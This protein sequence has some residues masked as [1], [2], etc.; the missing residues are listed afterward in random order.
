MRLYKIIYLLFSTLLCFNI[1][2]QEYEN[3]TVVAEEHYLLQYSENGEG[4]GPTAE[5]LKALFKE[6]KISVAINFMPWPRAYDMAYNNKNTIVLSLIRT[7]EREKYFHWIGIVSELSRV[8]ISLN[9]KPDNLITDISQAKDKLIAVTRDS[10]SFHELIKLGFNENKNL[11]IVSNNDSA[12][13][14]LLNGKVDLVYHDPN[15]V[16]EFI[17]KSKNKN[18]QINFTP[19]I[20]ADRRA[21]YIAININSDKA[22]VSNLKAAMAKYQQT[23]Q[24][25]YYLQ[26]SG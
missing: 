15:T 2:A 13:K 10:N 5:I 6:L 16:L 23:E 7:P 12:F 14:L 1:N 3:I 18:Q 26:K 19:I 25:R 11:Y 20:S 8:F 4:K 24:Y 9:S 22:L 17:A 21:S